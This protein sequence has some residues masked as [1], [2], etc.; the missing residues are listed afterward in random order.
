MEKRSYFAF[1]AGR[2]WFL[3][4]QHGV[5]RAVGRVPVSGRFQVMRG[6]RAIAGFDSIDRA[7]SFLD[8]YPADVRRGIK[9]V[10]RELRRV[11]VR[12]GR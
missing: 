12:P 5:D 7:T 1:P 8:G 11:V 2:E 9:V 4:I 10:D 6:A 3:A